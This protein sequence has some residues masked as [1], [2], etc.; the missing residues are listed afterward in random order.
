MIANKGEDFLIS[1]II[2]TFNRAHTLHLSIES[3][4]NQTSANWELI[5]ID[6]GSTDGTINLVNKYL[7]DNRFKYYFQKHQG[8]STARN[9]G[10]SKAEGDYIIFLDSDD[11]FTPNL[12]HQLNT[13]QIVKY[14]IIFWEVIRISE[15]NSIIDKPV[16][17]GKIYNKITANFLAG[18]VCYKKEIFLLAG[19]YDP[20]ISFGENYE[21]GIRISWLDNLKIKIIDF[22]FLKYNIKP[23]GRTSNTIENRL[24]SYIYQMEKHKL[25]YSKNNRARSKM[26][27][28]IGFVLEKNKSYSEALN[29]YK[30]SWLAYPLNI[31]PLLKILYFKII[32]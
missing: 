13:Y 27:Y 22:P 30:E 24:S 14:D 16:K 4:L 31:K 5:I 25:L 2:P 3:L 8:V 32:V 11:T 29:S 28:L 19:G 21:L 1:V 20:N 9:Y 7:Q 15:K 17:L 10:A 26:H 6:D 18:C 23:K 12:I